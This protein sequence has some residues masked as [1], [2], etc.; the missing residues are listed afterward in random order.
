MFKSEAGSRKSEVELCKTA[1]QQD[2]TT[3]LPTFAS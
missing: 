1:G 2:C 3:I